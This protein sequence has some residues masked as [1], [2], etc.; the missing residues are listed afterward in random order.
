MME[1]RLLEILKSRLDKDDKTGLG[2]RLVHSALGDKRSGV[3][4]SLSNLFRITIR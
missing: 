3:F 1:S 2:T 4:G